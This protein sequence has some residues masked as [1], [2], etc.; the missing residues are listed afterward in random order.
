LA[1]GVLRIIIAVDLIFCAGKRLLTAHSH[2]A[3]SS[4]AENP[5]TMFRST[6]KFSVQRL[7]CLEQPCSPTERVSV[8]NVFCG[9]S[10]IL[11]PF[12]VEI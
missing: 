6:P 1:A 2:P 7:L 11:F 5:D 8:G 9:D 4:Y 10:D 3:S 12:Q